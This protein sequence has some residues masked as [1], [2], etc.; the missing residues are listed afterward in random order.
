MEHF[1]Q[2]NNTDAPD[3]REKDIKEELMAQ[4]SMQEAS[5]EHMTLKLNMHETAE[6]FCSL[7][8]R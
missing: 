6:V 3:E 7:K 1:S 4:D 8:K 5:E 2:A